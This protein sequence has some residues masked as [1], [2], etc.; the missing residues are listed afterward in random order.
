MYLDDNYLIQKGYIEYMIVYVT[1]NTSF[2]TLLPG[3]ALFKSLTGVNK[4]S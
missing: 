2:Y 4:V 1:L 3:S